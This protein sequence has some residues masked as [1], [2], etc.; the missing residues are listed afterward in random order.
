M[1]NGKSVTTYD[2]KRPHYIDGANVMLSG[3][4]S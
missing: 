1:T 4:H 3:K 2:E